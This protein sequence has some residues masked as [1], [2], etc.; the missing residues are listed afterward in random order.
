MISERG[1]DYFDAEQIFDYVSPQE[2][3]EWG[4]LPSSNRSAHP[5][6]YV[7]QR[8]KNWSAPITG[9]LFDSFW[10]IHYIM[11]RR[12]RLGS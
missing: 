2:T 5:E 1:E 3:V 9:E 12:K 10:R 4:F 6:G 11:A 8:Y 7:A